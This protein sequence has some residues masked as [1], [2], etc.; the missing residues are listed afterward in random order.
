MPRIARTVFA[1]IPHH[2]TQRGNRRENVFF[3]E[4]DRDAY[5]ELLTEYCRDHEVKILAYCLMTNHVRLVA[6]PRQ[7]DG[8]QCVFKPVDMRHAQYINRQHGWSGHLWQGRFFSSPL[9]EAYLWFCVRHVERNPVRAGMAE[10]AEDY[11]RSSAAAHC[12]L[13]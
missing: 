10:R 13:K 4:G 1:D 9:D 12:G 7:E 2:V 11:P 3:T 5:L 8:L 6:V